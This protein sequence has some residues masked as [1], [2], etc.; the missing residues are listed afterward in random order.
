MDLSKYYNS[1]APLDKNEIKYLVV[2]H[3][4]TSDSKLTIEDIHQM[5]LAEGFTCVGYHAVILPDGRVQYGR[6]IDSVGA[7]AYEYNN[8]SLGVC[9]LGYFHSPANQKPTEAQLKSL[10]GL[11]KNWKNKLPG[12]IK[13]VGHRDLCATACP[14]DLFTNAMLENIKKQVSASSPSGATPPVSEKYPY[15]TF[16]EKYAKEYG[17]DPLFIASIIEQESSFNPKAISS[18]NAKGLMQLLSGTFGDCRK[19]LGLPTG[20]DIFDPETNIR[21]GCYYFSWLRKYLQSMENPELKLLACA[22]NQGP[23]QPGLKYAT[24]VMEKLEKRT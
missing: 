6:P 15:Q 8:C 4:A 13:I 10:V 17:F 3:S 11:L 12:R 20:A 19:A 7:H 23:N 16:I 22:Y 5:H 9:L 14:G 21:S 1:L 2:H 24:E 18:S